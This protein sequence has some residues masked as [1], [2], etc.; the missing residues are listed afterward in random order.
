VEVESVAYIVCDALGLDTSGYSFNYV[1]R[2]SG[3]DTDLMRDTAERVI[4][5]ATS[6]LK[7]LE[8]QVDIDLVTEQAS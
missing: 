1:A 8:M 7:G 2:W 4:G 3:G 5:C 6:I